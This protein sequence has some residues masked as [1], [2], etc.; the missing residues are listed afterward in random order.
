[1]LRGREGA[2]RGQGR[3]G[4]V[5]QHQHRHRV[6]AMEGVDDPVGMGGRIGMA[7][8]GN[9]VVVAAG[10]ARTEDGGG[11]EEFEP[12]GESGADFTGAADGEGPWTGFSRE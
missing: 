3:S 9:V 8:D 11:T 4:K 2:G 6:L 5:A 7:E 1:M 10:M 12:G